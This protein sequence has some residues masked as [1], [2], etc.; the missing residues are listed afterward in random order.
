[1]AWTKDNILWML[2]SSSGRDYKVNDIK[3][4][5]R[6]VLDYFTKTAEQNIVV[7]Q[8]FDVNGKKHDLTKPM[9]FTK[10]GLSLHCGYSSWKNLQEIVN[11]GDDFRKVLTCAETLIYKQK[12]DH[13]AVGVFNHS[14]IARDLGLIDKQEIEEK[15]TKIKIGFSKGTRD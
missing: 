15:V 2:R 5:E 13:A 12:F 14:I 3:E 7:N 8:V 6:L 10:E 11:Q 4:F 9:P 1:M